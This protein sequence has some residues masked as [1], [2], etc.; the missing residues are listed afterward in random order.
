MDHLLKAGHCSK[1]VIDLNT[2]ILTTPYKVGIISQV[3][4]TGTFRY[5]AQGQTM[6][7]SKRDSVNIV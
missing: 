2:L 5:L 1:H 7:N 4:K 3:G 6:N